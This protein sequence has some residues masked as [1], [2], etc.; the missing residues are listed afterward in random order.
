MGGW[1]PR[2]PLGLPVTCVRRNTLAF[3]GG[4][5]VGLEVHVD[6][7]VREGMDHLLDGIVDEDEADEGGEAFLSE[8]GDVLDNEA[9]VCGHQDKALDSRVEANPEA[10]L[11]VV[12]AIASGRQRNV[13]GL[14]PSSLGCAWLP[15]HTLNGSSAPA[16]AQ[17]PPPHQTAGGLETGTIPG[18]GCLVFEN[19]ENG[20]HEG[21]RKVLDTSFLTIW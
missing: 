18:W 17:M 9:G 15:R 7:V 10:E 21:G 14:Q 2:A 20:S 1:G 19:S 5:G 6:G 4:D 12:Q 13:G 8:A 3:V 16:L 11:H